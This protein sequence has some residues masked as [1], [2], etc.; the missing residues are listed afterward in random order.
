MCVSKSFG[1]LLFSR[2]ISSTEISC[3]ICIYL[4][5]HTYVIAYVAL[6]EFV[7]EKMHLAYGITRILNILLR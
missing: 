1:E 6:F 4:Y 7:H 3:G 5:V 2:V